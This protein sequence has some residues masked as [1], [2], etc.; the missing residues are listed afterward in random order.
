M[1]VKRAEFIALHFP[2]RMNLSIIIKGL[3]LTNQKQMLRLSSASMPN[4]AF[5]P[6]ECM[7]GIS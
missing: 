7:T 3:S 4:F 2:L 5:T 6:W 1:I